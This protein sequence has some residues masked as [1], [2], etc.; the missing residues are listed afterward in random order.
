MFL[1][2]YRENLSVYRIN[3]STSFRLLA[4]DTFSLFTLPPVYS[5]SIVVLCGADSLKNTSF[6]QAMPEEYKFCRSRFVIAFP[7][8]RSCRN[9]PSAIRTK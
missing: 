8:I 1:W 5:T 7:I 6:P 9:L 4:G 3:T 2:Y